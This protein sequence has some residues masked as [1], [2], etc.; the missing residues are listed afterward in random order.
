MVTV[1]RSTELPQR[2]CWKWNFYIK[3]CVF[4]ILLKRHCLSAVDLGMAFIATP[5]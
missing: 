1:F 2:C 4:P 3:L 5:I